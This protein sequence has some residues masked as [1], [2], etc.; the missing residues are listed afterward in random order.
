LPW[1][2][3]GKTTLRGGYSIS[4]SPLAN[5]DGYK[6][7]IATVP[8]VS[9]RF[10]NNGA[11][12]SNLQYMTLANI[13]S[14]IGTDAMRPQIQPM[15]TITG[16][17]NAISVYDDNAEPEPVADAAVK[18]YPDG[19]CPLYRDVGAQAVDQR[20]PEYAELHPPDRRA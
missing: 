10:T 14:I 17:S 1:L 18:Q 4:Y 2:G 8:G 6:G 19:G 3:K 13:G 15:Q 5:F 12:D 11:S 16:L 9:T 20:Q 7:I